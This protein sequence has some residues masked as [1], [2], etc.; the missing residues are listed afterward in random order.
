MR[1]FS[2]SSIEKWTLCQRRYV[3]GYFLGLEEGGSD[4]TEA[5]SRVHKL[6]EDTPAGGTP[7]QGIRWLHYDISALATSMHRFLPTDDVVVGNE[8]NFEAELHGLPFRGYI[9]RLSDQFIWDW[10]TTG[11]DRKWAKSPRKLKTDVQRLIYSEAYPDVPNARW[12][13]GLWRDIP[14]PVDSCLRVDRKA[15]K[16]AFRLNVLHPAQEIAVLDPNVDPLSLPLPTE[17]DTRTGKPKACNAFGKPCPA[18]EQCHGKA[19]RTLSTLLD[20]LRAENLAPTPFDFVPAGRFHET[21]EPIAPVGLAPSNGPLSPDPVDVLPPPSPGVTYLVDTLLID[22]SPISSLSTPAVFGH[23]VIVEASREVCA[24]FG[25]RNPLQMDFGK[26]AV[27]LA[28]AVETV[29]EAREAPIS[30]LVWESRTAEGRACVQS[31]CAR[32]RLVIK[33]GF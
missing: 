4:A 2:A 32:S 20:T 23:T 17:I 25:L 3:F 6:L 8:V 9:D 1:A 11:S 14:T 22:C 7:E 28:V 15:D 21:S 10:K 16:E 33:G 12:V 13:T 29:L 24:E 19:K 5:G 31:L 27:A 26:G 18:Y 30:V